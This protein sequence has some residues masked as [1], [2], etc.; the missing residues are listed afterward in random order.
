MTVQVLLKEILEKQKM[1]FVLPIRMIDRIPAE[2]NDSDDEL[3][4]LDMSLRSK[5][6]LHRIK[7]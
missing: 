2:E 6:D 7:R 3:P 5:P 4:V 1:D